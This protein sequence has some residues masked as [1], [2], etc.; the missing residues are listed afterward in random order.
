MCPMPC[1]RWNTTICAANT[2]AEMLQK[3]VVCCGHEDEIKY[4]AERTNKDGSREKKNQSVKLSSQCLITT[5][6]SSNDFLSMR[7]IIAA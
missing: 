5:R 7:T 2:V 1:S 4:A 6:P 3:I